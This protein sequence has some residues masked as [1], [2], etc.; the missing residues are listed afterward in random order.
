MFKLERKCS[1]FFSMSHIPKVFCS[2]NTFSILTSQYF[3]PHGYSDDISGFMGAT[4]L[5]AGI[6]AS[7]V[8]SP[9]FDRV[10]TSHLGRTIQV[11]VPILS[12]T[13]ISMIW[14]GKSS[15]YPRAQHMASRPN[16]SPMQSA[17]TTLPL[18]L[19]FPHS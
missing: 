13:W 2:V 3:S 14:A 9:L 11:L 15:A 16:L 7:A 6:I 12:A 18:C 5:L 19:S 4:L 10:L 17:P 1:P 8:T